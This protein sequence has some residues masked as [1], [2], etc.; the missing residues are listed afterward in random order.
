VVYAVSLYQVRS[1]DVCALTYIDAN[2]V[3]HGFVRNPFG[4]FATFDAPGAGTGAYQGT[5][6]SSDCP[7]SLNDWGAITGN[8]IDA[9]SVPHGYLRSPEGKIVTVDPQGTIFTWSSGLNDSSTTT[10]YYVDA[11][12]VYHGFLRIPD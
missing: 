5:G 10:G 12:D 7:V 8:Y 6:C 3:N 11:N 2:S 4:A 1:A 9:N